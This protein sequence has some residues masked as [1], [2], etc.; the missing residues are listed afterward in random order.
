MAATSPVTQINADYLHKLQSSLS[1]LLDGVNQQLNGLGTKGATAATLPDIY[2]VTSTL[3]VA[4]GASSFEAG[5]ALN[6][7]LKSMGTSV[8]EQL[9][10]LKKVLTDMIADITTTVNSFSG[11]ESLNDETVAQLNSDFQKT[12]SDISTPAGSGSGT[13]TPPGGT[14]TP[15][16]GTNKPAASG[17]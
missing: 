5:A 9:T 10:W 6:T 11:T 8:N 15:P 3:N 7:A 4:A 2:P 1:D 13:T 16:G 12:I 17:S 14:T